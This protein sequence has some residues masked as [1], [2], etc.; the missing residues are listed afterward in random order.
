VRVRYTW[1][2]ITETSAT[3]EQAFSFDRGVT[4]DTNW[5]MAATRVT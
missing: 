5:I 4:W 2:G 3:W 1:K